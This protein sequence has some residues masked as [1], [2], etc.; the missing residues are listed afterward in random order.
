MRETHHVTPVRP[1][2]WR[3]QQQNRMRVPALLIADRLTVDQLVSEQQDAVQWS[4]LDQLCNVAALPGIVGAAIGLPDIHPGYGFPI[5]G[6]AAFDA[7]DG[8]AVVGGIGFDINCGVRLIATPMTKQEVAPLI[9]QVGGD[10]FQA[11]PSGLGAEGLLRLD[12]RRLDEILRE[13]AAAIVAEGYGVDDDLLY[14]EEGGRLPDADP[15][16]VSDLAKQ[17]QFKQLGT[18]GSGNHYLE[19]QVVDRLLDAQAAESYGLFLDQVLISIHTGSRALGHQIGQDAL[20]DMAAAT[21]KYGLDVPEPELACAPIRST[22]GMRFLS[23][24]ACGANC[25]LA[26]R[27]MIAHRVRESLQRTLRLSPASVRTVYDVGH[28]NAKFEVHRVDGRERRLLVHRKGA[29]RAF[30]PSRAEAPDAYRTV[31]HPVVVGGTMGTAS[32]VLRGTETGMEETFGSGVHGAGR[33]LS[34]KKASKKFW[35]E[36]VVAQ[37]RADGVR[38]W[39]HSVRGISE[40]APGAYKDI[41][42]VV[43]ASVDAGIC[44]RVARLRPLAVIKG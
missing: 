15:S 17:R 29:T 14:C 8:V 41:E 38:L 36:S 44:R 24:V 25:A 30:G 2:V 13:G 12:R 6:V 31:G 32:Y 22:E 1:S 26:N 3:V 11:I 34:R 20:R 10:L 7:E 4:S 33:V 5:G 37:L 19:I 27:Q 40:E 43:D 39:T 42:T 35:G 28:N 9:E 23:A 18:L 21:V 16:T